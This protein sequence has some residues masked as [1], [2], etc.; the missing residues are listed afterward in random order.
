MKAN[1]QQG[2]LCSDNHTFMFHTHNARI[3][4][5]HCTPSERVYSP[6]TL[7]GN[8]SDSTRT[9]GAGSDMTRYTSI[10]LEDSCRRCPEINKRRRRSSSSSHAAASIVLVGLMLFPLARRASGF[11]G[12]PP[13]RC[14]SARRAGCDTTRSS[15]S[16]GSTNRLWGKATTGGNS[17]QGTRISSRAA[18]AAHPLVMVATDGSFS[19]ISQPIPQPGAATPVGAEP[20]V[21]AAQGTTA[22]LL[23]ENVAETSTSVAAAGAAEKRVE[24]WRVATFFFFWYAFN[25]GYNLSTKST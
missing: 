19:K 3:A 16:D 7:A 25:V 17:R 22:A 13:L 2:V 4:L 9:T 6:V 14:G 18:C 23:G 21:G 8:R 15:R 24:G 10:V 20:G 1:V 5:I 12:I 11:S